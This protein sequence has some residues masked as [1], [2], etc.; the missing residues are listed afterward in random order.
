V[1]GLVDH[2]ARRGFAAL[3]GSWPGEER[4]EPD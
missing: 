3:T 4:P 2:Y 1:R